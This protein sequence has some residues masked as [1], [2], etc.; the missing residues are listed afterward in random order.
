MR[1]QLE[2]TQEG[3]GSPLGDRKARQKE[4]ARAGQQWAGVDS[5]MSD[6]KLKQKV[7]LCL[8]CVLLLAKMHTIKF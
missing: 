7:V 5:A 6:P 4:K 2:R 3:G 1:W 8:M